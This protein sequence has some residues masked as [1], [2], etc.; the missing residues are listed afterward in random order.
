[1]KYIIAVLICFTL[2]GNTFA[3]TQ[4]IGQ[5]ETAISKEDKSALDALKK[6]IKEYNEI[7]K[8][9]S[10][11]VT[12]IKTAKE[13]LEKV[14]KD[15]E[16]LETEIE[17]KKEAVGL[18]EFGFGPAFFMISY[19]EEVISDSG[20]VRLRAN[21]TIDST[22]SRFNTSIGL[23]VHYDFAL[24][25]KRYG[26]KI[27]EETIW[28][29]SNGILITPFVGIFDIENGINGFAGGIMFGYWKGDK[30]FENRSSLNMSL[31]YTVH[32]NQLVLSKEIKEGEAPPAGFV[33]EDF[34]TKKDVS[35]LVFMLSVSTG[36]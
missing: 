18:S 16:K 5:A 9:A 21:G 32:R 27:G 25:G 29:K 7:I 13:D 14:I 24:L 22:G 12:Q 10:K 33:A 36:F 17:K 34:T 20:D 31:G 3:A 15:K 28:K 4:T 19:N 26:T 11:T 2:T 8:D 35:G 30:N 23:E 6:K 1:M